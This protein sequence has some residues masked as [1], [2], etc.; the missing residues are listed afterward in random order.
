MGGWVGGGGGGGGEKRIESQL[1]EGAGASRVV[2]SK[3][4]FL[5]NLTLPLCRNSFLSGFQPWFYTY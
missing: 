3:T 1:S 4:C 5:I 2:F